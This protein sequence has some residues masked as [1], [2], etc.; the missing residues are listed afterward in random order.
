MNLD[1]ALFPDVRPLVTLGW[2]HLL[3]F[4]VLVPLTGL[5][6][7]ARLLD[8]ASVPS[9]SR[10]Y[11]GTML[12]LLV[13]GAVSVWTARAQ[14]IALSFAQ[15]RAEGILA[16][17]IVL[18]LGILLV[19]PR[20]RAAVER[21]A[22]MVRLYA[23]S[24]GVERALWTAKAVLAGI[25]EE[26]SWRGVQV[27][28]LGSLFGSA[29][30]AILVCVVGFTVAHAV[31]DSKSL[32]I[33]AGFAIAFH[34][35]V[36]LS[37]SLIVPIAVHALYDIAAGLAYGRYVRVSKARAARASAAAPGL[38]GTSDAERAVR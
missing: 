26:I 6:S 37:G 19:L 17:A 4:G 21:G 13:F 10:N 9:R 24:T 12:L 18:V 30:P 33:V 23:P 7:R 22:P 20:W 28:L 27:T 25:S 8:A 35:L 2:Y 11:L 16:G 31:Q 32:P 34:L 5:R 38:R 1:A 29:A 3:L 36:A 15:P 14:G